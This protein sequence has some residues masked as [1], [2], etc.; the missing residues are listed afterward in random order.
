MEHHLT[1]IASTKDFRPTSRNMS[2]KLVSMGKFVCSDAQFPQHND[3]EDLVA[4]RKEL[5]P[6][7]VRGHGRG[8]MTC[9]AAS[10]PRG[11]AYQA[12]TELIRWAECFSNADI[13]MTPSVL[14]DG[15]NVP[16]ERVYW[17]ESPKSKWRSM[18]CTW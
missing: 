2:L 13:Y 14:C 15:R 6:G 7:P 1:K 9:P 12:Y 11:P 10:P 8:L 3:R 17:T 5:L 16:G 4:G 18:K